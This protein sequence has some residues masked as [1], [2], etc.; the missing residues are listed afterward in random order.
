M[1]GGSGDGRA[2]SCKRFSEQVSRSHR[3]C[4]RIWDFP[5]LDINTGN[6][7]PFTHDPNGRDRN[8]GNRTKP[9]PPKIAPLGR[10]GPI[11]IHSHM[12]P[13]VGRRTRHDARK[14]E[15]WRR[16]G[17]YC[18][19]W[20]RNFI[21]ADGYNRLDSSNRPLTMAEPSRSGCRAC[22][23]RA[24]CNLQNGANHSQVQHWSNA[25]VIGTSAT[26]LGS[27][28]RPEPFVSSLRRHSLLRND[29][30]SW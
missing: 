28:A 6:D 9:D 1:A 25:A 8:P 23:L 11:I 17:S 22:Q 13:M 10:G 7:D 15:R 16:T 14:H 24:K 12:I 26:T 29:H 20:R 18:Q 21:W 4:M 2:H 19:S 5:A 27:S 30:S 3:R